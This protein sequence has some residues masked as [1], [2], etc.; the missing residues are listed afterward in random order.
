VNGVVCYRLSLVFLSVLGCN[1]LAMAVVT[2]DVVTRERK[3]SR[4]HIALR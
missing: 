3:H 4:P 1:K 2:N